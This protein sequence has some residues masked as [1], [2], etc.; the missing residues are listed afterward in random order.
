MSGEKK[1]LWSPEVRHHRSQSGLIVPFAIENTHLAHMQEQSYTKAA[2]FV[3]QLTTKIL[4]WLDPQPTDVILDIGC[5]DGVLTAN[6]AGRCQKIYGVDS[7][8]SMIEA[9]NTNVRKQYPNSDFI[10]ADCRRVSS[11]ACETESIQILRAFQEEKYD[12]VFSNAAMH[13]ILRYEG[14]RLDFFNDVHDLLKPGGSF[15]FEMGGH[16]N[17]SETHT[18]LISVLHLKFGIPL[19]KIRNRGDP[20]FFPS[21]NWMRQ[22]LEG[23]GF[24]VERLEAEHRP[25]KCTVKSEDGSGG[26]HGWVRLMGASF[27]ELLDN[28]HDR[29]AAVATVCDLLVDIVTRIEDDTEWLGYVRLRAVAVKAS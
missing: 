3:P 18:A 2:S 1:D 17:V 29:D 26:L 20:W 15:V 4:K 11:D 5:G 12:R 27:L 28:Q 25:T 8:P 24:V 13:W 21:E 22:T 10:V 7:S 19:E 16:G 9:A 6:I 23:A 14:N